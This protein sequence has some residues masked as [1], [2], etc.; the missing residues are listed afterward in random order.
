MPEPVVET[1]SGKVRGTRTGNSL[2]FLGIRYAK[3]ERFEAPQAVEPWP[4][5]AD[6]TSFGPMAPQSDPR[7]DAP[8]YGIILEKM[9]LG[10]G[11]AP[12]ED[13][14]CQYLNIWTSELRPARLKPVMVWLHPGFFMVGTGAS[15]NGAHLAGRGDVVVVSLNHRLNLFG[16]THLDDIADGFDGSGNAGML[17]IVAALRWVK[18]SIDRFGGDPERIMVFGASGGGMKTAWLMTSPASEGLLHRAG[19]QSG[20]CLRLMERDEASRISEQL[21]QLLDIKP[22]DVARL[23]TLPVQT[24]LLAYHTLRTRNRPTRFTHL[25]SFAPVIDPGLLPRHPFDPDATPRAKD[26]PMLLG[27]NRQD[28]AFFAG[29]D[30]SALELDD[31]G[32][33]A[34]LRERFGVRGELLERHYRADDPEA[35]ASD[36]WLRILSDFSVGGP[37]LAQAERKARLGGAPTFV[38]RFDHPSPAFEGRLGAVHSSETGYVFGTPGPFS[39]NSPQALALRDAMGDRWVHFAATG[40]VNPSDGYLLPEWPP[41]GPDRNVMSLGAMPRLLTDPIPHH[42]EW[43]IP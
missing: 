26:I 32:L 24:L 11:I 20:P 14:H 22:R 21:L 13:E 17:D 15:G 3:A 1:H 28:M 5:M 12:V 9:D 41:F 37:V 29:D 38:Y 23:R 42:A 2:A 6:A 43:A 31:E 4:G 35:R 19:A 30:L 33:A 40:D 18:T 36:V 39:D 34:R 8:G 10:G 27:W 25:A 16:F 7:P